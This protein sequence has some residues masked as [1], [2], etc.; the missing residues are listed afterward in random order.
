MEL[1]TLLIHFSL[2]PLLL[3]FAYLYKRFPPKKINSLYGYR[4][5]RSMKNQ[6][7]WECGNTYSAQALLL[8]A[9]GCCLVQLVA[10]SLTDLKWA[11]LWTAGFL[12]AGIMLT[13]PFT[14]RHLKQRGF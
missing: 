6:E 7:A 11:V 2:G 8:V 14:E 4:T 5:S 1:T 9:L 13:I 10:F 3:I 12:V